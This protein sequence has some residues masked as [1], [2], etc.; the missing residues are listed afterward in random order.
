MLENAL[1]EQ[2]NAVLRLETRKT[3][4]RKFRADSESD[5]RIRLSFKLRILGYFM[6]H[7]P[8]YDEFS[9]I[10]HMLFYILN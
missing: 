8:N 10:L 9:H 1:K 2:L 3:A 7:L 5:F 4:L 6:A